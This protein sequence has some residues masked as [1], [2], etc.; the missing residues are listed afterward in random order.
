MEFLIMHYQNYHYDIFPICRLQNFERDIP[1]E[2][3][4]NDTFC[5][6]L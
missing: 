4:M 6:S 5:P 1:I 3:H 2:T